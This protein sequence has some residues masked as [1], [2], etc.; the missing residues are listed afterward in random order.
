MHKSSMIFGKLFFDLYGLPHHRILDVGSRNYEGALRDFAPSGS[1][2]VGLD[3]EAGPG[4]DI[5]LTDPYHFPVDSGA[6]DIVT[7]SSCF[8]HSEFFWLTFEEMIRV[9][10]PGGLIYLNSPSNGD[11]H[12]YPV[13]CWRFYPDSGI[14]LQNWARR[15]GQQVTLVESFVGETMDGIYNDFVAVF[16][17]GGMSDVLTKRRMTERARFTNARTGAD[18]GIR[19]HRQISPDQRRMPIRYWLRR[20][21]YIGKAFS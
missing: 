4:V 10:K 9:L 2:N 14:A 20:L 1:E 18:E 8:E 11:F 6:F 12:R 16:V 7:A 5:V 15:Q 3:F 19:N 21:R 17:K 13:D